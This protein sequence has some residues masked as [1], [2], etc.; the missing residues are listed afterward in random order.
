MS[1]QHAVLTKY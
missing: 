1:R